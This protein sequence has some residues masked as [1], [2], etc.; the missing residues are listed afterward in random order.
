VSSNIADGSLKS[1]HIN[2]AVHNQVAHIVTDVLGC[3]LIHLAQSHI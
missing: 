2:A 1:S 3:A